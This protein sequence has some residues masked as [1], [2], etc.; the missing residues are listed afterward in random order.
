MRLRA[1]L[2]MHCYSVD[3]AKSLV[4]RKKAIAKD[5]AQREAIR[6]HWE[7]AVKLHF[8]VRSVSPYP[9]YTGLT[10]PHHPL[11]FWNSFMSWAVCD[12]CGRK[13]TSLWKVPTLKDGQWNSVSS[14]LLYL[15][16]L[17]VAVG[18]RCNFYLSVVIEMESW[19]YNC[20]RVDGLRNRTCSRRAFI[21]FCSESNDNDS[22]DVPGASPKW[23]DV[24]SDIKDYSW[25]LAYPAI[26]TGITCSHK[27]LWQ[28]SCAHE[29]HTL[30]TALEFSKTGSEIYVSPSR[31]HWPVYDPVSR[32]YVDAS[33]YKRQANQAPDPRESLLD[34]P[35]EDAWSLSIVRVFHDLKQD[36]VV[37][38]TR[39]E[40]LK[41]LDC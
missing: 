33:D 7:T 6:L 16:I 35:R 4:T 36:L 14:P 17:G 22:K 19:A 30:E 25:S 3:L 12:R 24:V 13:D 8:G 38:V 26:P 32:S 10:C 34:L 40:S 29:V 41:A 11:Q 39:P 23:I 18:R 20:G 2:G 31:H 27:A 15:S 28:A 1:D 5:I 21:F 37:V 9:A